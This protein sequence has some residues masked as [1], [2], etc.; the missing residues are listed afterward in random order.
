MSKRHLGKTKLKSLKS[1]EDNSYIKS[2]QVQIILLTKLIEQ[3]E[4]QLETQPV[5][6]RSLELACHALQNVRICRVWLRSVRRT[7]PSKPF[8]NIISNPIRKIRSY[9][10]RSMSGVTHRLC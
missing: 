4:T 3:L 5:C 9:R 8:T 7:Q 10:R 1:L 2:E 6:L